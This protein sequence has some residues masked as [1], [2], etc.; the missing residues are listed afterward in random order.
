MQKPALLRISLKLGNRENDQSDAG[1]RLE[2]LIESFDL[3]ELRKGLPADG[4]D[5]HGA[6]PADEQ[7]R[8]RTDDGCHLNSL[9]SL[10]APVNT[11]L[12][13]LTRPRISSGVAICINVV[14]IF[15][16]TMSAAPRTAIATSDTHR[17]SDSPNATVQI[18]KTTTVP[19]M[20]LPTDRSNVIWVDMIPLTS[21]PP[22]PSRFA[23]TLPRSTLHRE[24]PWRR[25]ETAR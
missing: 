3:G 18:P 19:N 8:H 14:R 20:I 12:T 5:D 4:G 22:A 15:T 7:R 16:L 17:I 10:D 23:G 2:L 13:A 11:E 6:E 25:R 24:Y 9:I 1:R 21:A